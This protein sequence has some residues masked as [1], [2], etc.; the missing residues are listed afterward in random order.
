MSDYLW[1]KTGDTDE[2]VERLENL[3]G[4]LRYQPRTLELPPVAAPAPTKISH[5]KRFSRP[6]L[7]IAAAL[8]LMLLAGAWLAALRRGDSQSETVAVRHAP[9]AAQ[10]QNGEAPERMGAQGKQQPPVSEQKKDAEQVAASHEGEVGGERIRRAMLSRRTEKFGRGGTFA[11]ST[12]RHEVAFVN[13]S[14]GAHGARANGAGEVVPTREQQLAKQQLMFALRLTS[15]KFAEVQKKTQ[16]A[17]SVKPA[18]EER[19][20]TR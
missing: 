6:A 10:Q 7:A 15:T 14:A 13:A 4:S 19:N 20:K 17:E 1:D 18:S 5:F 3:L 12:G 16:D 11:G 9:A 8:V 2:E